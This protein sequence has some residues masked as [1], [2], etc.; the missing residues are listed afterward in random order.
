MEFRRHDYDA[1]PEEITFGMFFDKPTLSVGPKGGV[2]EWESF[3]EAKHAKV[4]IKAVRADGIHISNAQ[5]RAML[6]IIRV[7]QSANPLV[8]FTFMDGAHPWCWGH[9]KDDHHHHT[10]KES[11]RLRSTDLRKVL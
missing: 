7:A 1:W 11:M 8:T 3:R 9:L 6:Q 2:R 10:F 5:V 4:L